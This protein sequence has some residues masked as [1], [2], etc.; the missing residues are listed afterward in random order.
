[1]INEIKEKAGAFLQVAAHP[2]NPS[3]LGD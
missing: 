1:M 3:F 2:C